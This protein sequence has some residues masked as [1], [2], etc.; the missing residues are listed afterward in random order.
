METNNNIRVD[1]N[2]QKPNTNNSIYNSKPYI[3][4]SASAMSGFITNSWNG[5][6]IRPISFMPVMA[7]QR[8]YS[9]TL[10]GSLQMLTPK[11]P[12]AQKLK[13][14]FK[15]FFVP[16]SRVMKNYEKF[17]AHKGG[18][19][20]EKISTLPN[21]SAH[22]LTYAHSNTDTLVRP[23]TDTTMWRDCYASTYIPRIYSGD[24]W[25]TSDTTPTLS[26]PKMNW[27]PIRGF[28]AIYNDFLRH[29]ALMRA[30]PEYD[31]DDVS[32]DEF[33]ETIPHVRD[34][35]TAQYPQLR[36]NRKILKGRKQDS[37]YTDWR[38]SL[39]G[40]NDTTLNSGS[41]IYRDLAKHTEW[42][43]LM[44]QSRT[45]ATDEQMND[46]DIIS[47]LRGSKTLTEKRVQFLG[48]QVV[49][50]NYS[51]VPQTTYNA[52]N[53]ISDEFR[54]LGQTGAF[55]YTYF[56]CPLIIGQEFKEDGFIH[57]IAQTSADV[58][59]ENGINRQLLNV[60]YE[61]LYKPD[62]MTLKDDVIYRKEFGVDLSSNENEVVGYKRKFS[63]LFTMPNIIN[64]DTTNNPIYELY[65]NPNPSDDD[66]EVKT[67]NPVPTK[68]YYSFLE[69]PNMYGN[70]QL[71]TLVF[72][73]T[74]LM[75]NKNQAIENPTTYFD[76]EENSAE[77][78]IYVKGPNQI[79]F[80]G[81]HEAITELPVDN[82]IKDNYTPWSEV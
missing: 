18:S 19:E 15:V 40:M 30:L 22:T 48:M 44:A 37:Y 23:I 75:I 78:Q 63:E 45:E 11:V 82:S 35:N 77:R 31:T 36:L 39:E 41:P 64:G 3:P 73:N 21:P 13:T 28:K 20:I 68:D 51:R 9:Y 80:H 25:L 50:M 59:F 58:I 79:F 47:R 12:A 52:D 8:L 7:G 17:L 32:W 16:N 1:I 2:A 67:G 24:K 33:Y 65:A 62:L 69:N 54:N 46:W 55:S 53:S 4:K 10:K 61:D 14:Y 70:N 5:G 60:E 66:V 49:D 29:K 43:K 27:L 34:G 74:D 72:D 6:Y 76:D 81:I 26:M 71:N 42:Q 38:T 56:E 57:V